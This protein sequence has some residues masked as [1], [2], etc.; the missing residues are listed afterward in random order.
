MNLSF[1]DK[2]ALF[3]P[4]LG[5]EHGYISKFSILCSRFWFE[6]HFTEPCSSI[7]L[8]RFR[9]SNPHKPLLKEALLL[10][11]SK[12]TNGVESRFIAV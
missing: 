8:G 3:I 7:I 11:A 4:N 10:R 1:G 12:V 6:D 9:S 2:V 5:I